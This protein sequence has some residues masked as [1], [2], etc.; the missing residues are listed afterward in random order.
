MQGCRLSTSIYQ[1]MV[2]KERSRDN[3]CWLLKQ[4]G[5]SKD[6]VLTASLEFQCIFQPIIMYIYINISLNL[7]IFAATMVNNPTYHIYS[8]CSVYVVYWRK[9]YV[10]CKVYTLHSVLDIV[11][12]RTNDSM[13]LSSKFRGKLSMF[14]QWK[15]QRS[16]CKTAN[17]VNSICNRRTI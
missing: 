6:G 14:E 5:I 17:V 7:P 15:R 4:G 8:M 13:Q 1:K 16:S 3:S 12:P 9:M 2:R 11:Q 10:L